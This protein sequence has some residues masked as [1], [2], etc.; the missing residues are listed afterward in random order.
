MLP[1]FHLHTLAHHLVACHAT[2]V[3]VYSSLDIHESLAIFVLESSATAAAAAAAAVESRER[4]L[5]CNIDVVHCIVGLA[6]IKQKRFYTISCHQQ[7]VCETPR[8]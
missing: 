1:D 3:S 8:S 5:R 2:L 6:K 7:L 4:L